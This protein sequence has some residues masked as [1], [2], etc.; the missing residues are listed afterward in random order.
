VHCLVVDW[1]FNR[2]GSRS[3]FWMVRN[4]KIYDPIECEQC[5]KN[6]R[7]NVFWIVLDECIVS[8]DDGV[9]Y[10]FCSRKCARKWVEEK[11]GFEYDD[12]KTV[13][14]EDNYRF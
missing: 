1:F 14:E 6:I 8:E 4:M 9:E 3:Y 11:I 2:G 7:K 10:R 12:I 5:N 13:Q